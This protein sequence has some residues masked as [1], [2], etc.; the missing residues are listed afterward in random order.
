ML[1][2]LQSDEQPVEATP[3]SGHFLQVV[4]AVAAFV[5]VSGVFVAVPNI[6]DAETCCDVYVSAPSSSVFV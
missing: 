5:V 3:E 6:L 1:D 4:K 2:D